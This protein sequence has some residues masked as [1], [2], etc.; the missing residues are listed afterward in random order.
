[1]LMSR[2][3][4][5]DCVC[6]GAAHRDLAPAS[7]VQYQKTVEWLPDATDLLPLGVQLV[8]PCGRRLPS[9]AVPKVEVAVRMPGF[10]RVGSIFNKETSSPALFSFLSAGEN[11]IIL[12]PH[13]CLHTSGN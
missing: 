6:I 13:L 1:M 2:I 10:S 5:P 4:Q 9:R 12:S 7:T 8:A 11:E 3:P